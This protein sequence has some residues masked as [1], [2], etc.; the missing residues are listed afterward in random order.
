MNF[1]KQL[2]VLCLFLLIILLP[3]MIS[4]LSAQ[5]KPGLIKRLSEKFLSNEDKNDRSSSTIVIPTLGFAQETGFEYGIGGVYNF[6]IHK[7]NIH[8]KSSNIIANASMTTKNQK[9]IKIESDIWTNDNDY[10]FVSEIRLRDW[11]FNF[12]GL[13]MHTL[14]DDEERI[15]QKKF[16]I[17]LE[18]ERKILD[19]LYLGLS[20]KYEHLKYNYPDTS[21]VFRDAEMKGKN[22]GQHFAFGP[23]FSFDSRNTNTYTT[24]GFYF[25]GVFNISPKL[26]GEEDFHGTHLEA[27]A[28][29]FHPISEKIAI[30]SQVLFRNTQGNLPP[31]YAL[32][33]LGGSKTMRGYYEGRYLGKN[34]LTG[35]A[36]V[37]YRAFPRLGFTLFSGTGT[38][39][40][41]KENQRWI[42]SAGGG[43]RYFYS[44]EH[45]GTLRLDY[46]IGEKRPGE[47]RQSGF[48]LSISE[49]F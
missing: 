10:H 4:P 39:F 31:Y 27:D 7:E 23:I 29:Y 26:W 25:R 33:P 3:G 17:R 46:A 45:K 5:E 1:K 13:G 43:I 24:Q 15:G 11:P 47:N 16:L 6:Y 35:Q 12:Y 20:V 14:A 36:E 28:R 40:S 22:G 32:N 48:Y 30:G 42:G 19:R 2:S 34:Y 37:R 41:K 38:A 49:A 8:N 18:S 21:V 9:N 44:L